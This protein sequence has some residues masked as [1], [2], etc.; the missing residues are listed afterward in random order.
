MAL[1]DASILPFGG[2]GIPANENAGVSVPAP[3]IFHGTSAPTTGTF[4]VGDT[5]MNGLPAAATPFARTTVG[6]MCI[7]AS[8]NGSGAVFQPLYVAALQQTLT[9]TATSG[10]LTN[11]QRLI[12]LNPA[13]TGTYSLPDASANLAAFESTFKNLASGSVTLTPLGSNSYADA[14][15]IT[16]AQ[17]G[18]VTL[19]SNAGTVWYKQS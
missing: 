14:A 9:T 7:T 8:T 11:G 3:R 17:F 15:A 13:S 19:L 2:G 1:N 4:N 16:L 6:W 12:L 10:T 5:V 18:A